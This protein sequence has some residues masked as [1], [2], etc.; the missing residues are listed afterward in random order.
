MALEQFHSTIFAVENAISITFSECVHVALVILHAKLM[1]P[2]FI[3]SLPAPQH[4][5]RLIS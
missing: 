2:I 4:F 3:C 1:G 5:F